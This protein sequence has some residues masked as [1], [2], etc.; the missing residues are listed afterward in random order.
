MATLEELL[1]NNP[2]QMQAFL[3]QGP[4]PSPTNAMSPVD[5]GTEALGQI[6]PPTQGIGPVSNPDQYGALMDSGATNP[7]PATDDTPMGVPPGNPSSH[8]PAGSVPPSSKSPFQAMG[9][10]M[11]DASHGD[12][13]NTVAALKDAQ[14][15]SNKEKGLNDLNKAASMIQAGAQGISKN[16][17]TPDISESNKFWDEQNKQADQK[18]QQFKDLTE[19]EKNDPNSAAS[20]K[21]RAISQPML[22]KIGIKLPSNMSFNEI[23]KNFPMFTKMYDV[24]Q[25]TEARREAAHESALNRAAMLSSKKEDKTTDTQNK[26]FA[27]TMGDLT[28]YRGAKDVGNAAEALRNSDAAM[29]LIN[30]NP[31]YNKMSNEQ[32]NLLAAEVAKIATGGA[33]TEA[34]TKDAKA[35]T[36]QSQAAHFWS[37]VSGKP[38]PAEL[39]AFIKQNKD[40]LTHLNDVNHKIVTNFKQAKLAGAF[41]NFS[42][43]QKQEALLQ[44]P[45]VAKNLG[46][47]EEQLNDP[48]LKIPRMGELLRNS[49]KAKAVGPT[50]TS[51]GQDIVT[52]ANGKKYL[53]DHNTKKVIKEIP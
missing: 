24:Q 26:T 37:E 23:E 8:T 6:A 12:T 31:D 10:A 11:M 3:R 19:Q 44:H 33:A 43:E 35:K 13:M 40:Y 34:A 47:T 25:Q 36:V 52:A 38:T 17:K 39:G 28:T 45:D 4:T 41:D 53:V 29:T 20:N 50:T 27:K 1:K 14:D 48:N 30:M 7:A 51:P 32:Y 18:V 15:K 46:V 42:D 21:M 5:V 2:D 49:N 22:A 9:Q 16:A